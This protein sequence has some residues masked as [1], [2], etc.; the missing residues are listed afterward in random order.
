MGWPSERLSQDV[1]GSEAWPG[2]QAAGSGSSVTLASRPEQKLP[3]WRGGRP[4]PFS[5]RPERTLCSCNTDDAIYFSHTGAKHLY[6]VVLCATH[7]P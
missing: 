7:A 1:A 2:P 5:L 6:N 3:G 4:R